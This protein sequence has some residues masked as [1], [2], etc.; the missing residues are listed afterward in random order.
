[1]YLHGAIP[2]CSGCHD[3]YDELCTPST[4]WSVLQTDTYGLY[5][6]KWSEASGNILGSGGSSTADFTSPTTVYVGIT[7]AE[8][9]RM[10]ASQYTDYNTAE[11]NNLNYYSTSNS[12]GSY[13]G[14][15]QLCYEKTWSDN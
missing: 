7:I 13:N 6:S 10:S 15:Q 14:L 1:M 12:C 11:M 4:C 8:N 5:N 2:T 3:L 9:N